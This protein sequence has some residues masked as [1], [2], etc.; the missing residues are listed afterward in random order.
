MKP[1]NLKISA[2]GPY[3]DIEEIDFNKFGQ[4]GIFLVTG[5]TGAGK[6]TIFDAICFALYGEVSGQDRTPD[7]LRSDFA[8][9]ETKTY[10][11]LKFIHKGQIY[12][13]NRSPKYK[14]NKKNGDGYTTSIP[15]ATL[16]SNGEVL[17]TNVLDVTQK[18]TNILGIDVK[19]FKQISMI[20]QGAFLELLFADTKKRSDIFRKIFDTNLFYKIGEKLK[21]NSSVA[22]N[23]LENNTQELEINRQN[24]KWTKDIGNINIEMTIQLLK[25]L[26]SDDLKNKKEF[27]DKKDDISKKIDCLKVEITQA[28]IVNNNIDEYEILKIKYI[29]QISKK[30][31]I[32]KK[33]LM[34]K[35]NKKSKDMVFPIKAELDKVK[36][37]FDA[38]SLNIKILEN[39]IK[40]LNDSFEIV[41]NDYALIDNEEVKIKKIEERLNNLNS[42]LPLFSKLDDINENISQKTKTKIVLEDKM[43]KCLNFKKENEDKVK[44]MLFFVNKISEFKNELVVSEN[45]FITLDEKSKQILKSICDIDDINKLK[46]KLSIL[47]CDY[48]KIKDSYEKQNFIYQ[49]AQSRFLNEQAGILATKLEDGKPCLVCGSMSHPCIARTTSN[50]VSKDEL[51]SLKENLTI[52]DKKMANASN[53]AGNIL[54]QIEAKTNLVVRNVEIPGNIDDIKLALNTNLNT[55]NLRLVEL[56]NKIETLKKEFENAKKIEITL[57]N[58][59]AELDKNIE[60]ITNITNDIQIIQTD[61]DTL[62]GSLSMAKSSMPVEFETKKQVENEIVKNNNEV[63]F[64][65]D[66]VF[67]IRNKYSQCS[68]KIIAKNTTLSDIL[69]NLQKLKLEKE[70]LTKKYIEEF[71]KLGFESEIKYLD[72]I[73]SNEEIEL[74]EKELSDYDLN[75]KITLENLKRLEKLIYSKE[76][77]DLFILNDKF[78]MLSIEIKDLELVKDDINIRLS[79]N[80][81]VLEKLEKLYKINRKLEEKYLLVRDLSDSANGNLKGKQRLVFEQFVQAT[82]FNL[83]IKASNLRLD[84]MSSSRYEL[85][86]KEESDKLSEK[87]GLELDV[88]DNYTGKIRNV[89]S[90][91]GGESFKAALSLALGFSDTIQSYA[92]GIVVDTM[93]IDEGFGTLDEESLE[94]ALNTLNDL[95]FSNRLIGVISHVNELKERIDKKIYITKTIDGSHIEI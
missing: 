5:D 94:Q 82:Y 69:K 65:K 49:D 48:E 9:D 22:K 11:E 80:K 27:E 21:I 30:D 12:L 60:N 26:I 24:I 38:Q 66:N 88:L 35:L 54:A 1:I 40:V 53:E 95:T 83:V 64:K 33:R 2:F 76:K 20:A 57:K 10:V 42:I 19:Q 28:E 36:K 13:I 51:D 14:K 73:I 62:S 50:V 81:E 37:I 41:K 91:S 75:T 72:S 18:V 6:T 29:D 58:I 15:T 56:K 8:T 68:E 61:I 70:E 87:A 59:Q 34:V 92:G 85:V 32:D 25:D 31:C 89:K 86:R 44:E 43:K 74:I 45:E 71:K 23:E 84:K 93:F 16:I 77:I 4:S 67:K 78:K 46:Q 79:N 17:A 3:S 52:I 63:V 55:I 39:E 47:Q 90:L 7:I